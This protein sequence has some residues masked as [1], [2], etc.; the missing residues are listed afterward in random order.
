MINGSVLRKYGAHATDTLYG[1]QYRLYAYT[2]A[3]ST[4]QTMWYLLCVVDKSLRDRIVDNGL[5]EHVFPQEGD[6]LEL[7]FNA[8]Q[9]VGRLHTVH[10]LSCATNATSKN[11]Y[12]TAAL[13]QVEGNLIKP[14]LY[15]QTNE[16]HFNSLML[17]ET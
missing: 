17:G 9:A 15:Y 12:G 5:E 6:A 13:V 7:Q 8:T 14:Y 10:V 11:P 1:R 4:N 16:S 2:N 3:P